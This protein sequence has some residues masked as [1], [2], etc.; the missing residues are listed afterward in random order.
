MLCSHSHINTVTNRYAQGWLSCGLQELPYDPLQVV[1]LWKRKQT[2]EVTEK[3]T[4]AAD[5]V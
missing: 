4:E 3:Q 5:V 2:K 1:I